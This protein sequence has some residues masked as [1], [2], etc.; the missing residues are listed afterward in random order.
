MERLVLSSVEIRTLRDMGIFHSHPRTRM[1]AQAIVRLS[2]GLTLQQVANEFDV[3]L[4]SVEQWRQLW[5]QAK[6]FWR[7]FCSLQRDKLLNEVNSILNG[8]GTK[9]TINFA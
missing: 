7:R 6:Y 9:F 3:H 4:N 2:Q 1:R 8:F 5:K